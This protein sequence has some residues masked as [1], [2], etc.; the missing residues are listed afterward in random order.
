MSTRPQEEDAGD[1]A[2]LRLSLSYGRTRLALCKV[3]ELTPGVRQG[4]LSYSFNPT[5]PIRDSVFV[6]LAYVSASRKQRTFHIDSGRT[7]M[8][9]K[10]LSEGDF[11]RWTE[12]LRT[13]VG[14]VQERQ[15]SK[16]QG[17]RATAIVAGGPNQ[18]ATTVDLVKIFGAVA[19]MTA[20][21]RAGEGAGRGS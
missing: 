4:A 15:P 7:V 2:P 21:R 6:S 10:A 13:F 9:F 18:M 1:G 12:A 5:S 20:V 11:D 8:H 3:H 17:Q 16:G 14:T 19:R